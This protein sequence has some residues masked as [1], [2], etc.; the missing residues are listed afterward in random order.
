MSM[1]RLTPQFSG[2]VPR[3][4][5]T[6]Y[7]GPLQLLVAASASRIE[8]ISFAPKPSQKRLHIAANHH[9]PIEILYIVPPILRGVRI[10]EQNVV[11]V[12][13]VGKREHAIGLA[14]EHTA[15]VAG[16]RVRPLRKSRDPKI[17]APLCYVS[18][19]MHAIYVPQ[20]RGQIGGQLVT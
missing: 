5:A 20:Q 10:Q 11:S 18:P 4:P 19:E 7:H 2:R 6:T 3:C 14:L 12:F 13:V 15:M 9:R 17:A 1:R 8:L 16:C